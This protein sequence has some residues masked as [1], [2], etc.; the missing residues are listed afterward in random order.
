MKTYNWEDVN[1][2]GYFLDKLEPIP[3]A[4][5]SIQKVLQVAATALS[6]PCKISTTPA[7]ATPY[8]C[9]LRCDDYRTRRDPYQKTDSLARA[10]CGLP[11]A[12]GRPALDTE[13]ALKCHKP[14]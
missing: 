14:Q 10:L 2:D 6:I 5:R 11:P 13:T 9:Q 12:H 8:G 1:H 7:A 4:I 3:S